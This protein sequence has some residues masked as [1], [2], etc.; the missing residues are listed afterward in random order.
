MKQLNKNQT[1]EEF[2][3]I[4]KEGIKNGFL[5]ASSDLGFLK[6]LCDN[7]LYYFTFFRNVNEIQNR[8]ELLS[9]N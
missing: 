2:N 1:V 5:F 7:L 8:K 4:L 6:E 3:K 9:K